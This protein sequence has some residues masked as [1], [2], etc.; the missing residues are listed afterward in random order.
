MSQR[1]ALFGFGGGGGGRSGATLTVATDAGVTVTIARGGLRKSKTADEQGKA[2]FKWLRLGVYTVTISDGTDT[3]SDTVQVLGD[4]TKEI[5]I[6]KIYGICRDITS[7]SPDWTRTDDAVGMQAIEFNFPRWNYK[8]YPWGDMK[9]VKLDTG[10]EMVKIP[11][12]WFRRY[13]EGNM[14]HIKIADHP[15]DGF[16]LHPAFRHGGKETDCIYVGRFQT[17]KN[18]KSVLG[19]AGGTAITTSLTRAQFRAY[20]REKGAGWGI[21]DISALSAIQ[22]LALVQ[23]ASNNLQ[24]IICMGY[25]GGTEPTVA[26]HEIYVFVPTGHSNGP[27]TGEIG[28]GNTGPLYVMQYQYVGNFWGNVW[29]FVDGINWNGGTYY[30]CND[31]DKYAD[32]TTT[33]YTALSFKGATGWSAAYITREGMDTG[34][35]EHIF[36][37]EAVGG[38]EET[39]F[40]DGCYSASGWRVMEHGGDCTSMHYAGLF[41]ASFADAAGTSG[42]KVGCRLMYIP[43]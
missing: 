28:D 13:R 8:R 43:E 7:D 31:P 20:A 41:A 1:V 16:R 18:N 10:D 12:F 5:A 4:C 6:V 3:A 23:Y 15:V 37:P 11:K 25:V 40:C 17:G 42:A 39:Y 29:Q 32:D 30:V 26:G 19:G 24:D 36:L 27:G 38:S 9:V 33:G 21:W 34:G 2:V 35:N 22:M 14:E